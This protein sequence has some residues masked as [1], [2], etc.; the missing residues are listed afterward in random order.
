MSEKGFSE[1]M[2]HFVQSFFFCEWLRIIKLEFLFFVTDVL[3][4]CTDKDM[5]YEK[6]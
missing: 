2:L 3:E 5:L 4:A 1:L 6:P